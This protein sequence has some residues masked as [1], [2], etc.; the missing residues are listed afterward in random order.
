[1]KACIKKSLLV[2]ALGLALAGQAT[3]Q[4]LTVLYSFT[5]SPDGS[6]P[7][8][9]LTLSGSALYGT[10]QYGGEQNNPGGGTVFKINTDGSGE[11]VLKRFD[12]VNSFG[13]GLTPLAGLVTDG[14]MLYGT[15]FGGG[16]NPG[17][18]TVFKMNIN[19]TGYTVLHAFIRPWDGE[20]PTAGLTLSGNTLYGTANFGPSNK[21]GMVY[22]VK[23]DGTDYMG[24]H[25]F[26]TSDGAHPAADLVLSG[27]GVLYGT[28]S[29]G[30]TNGSVG[31]VFSLN[32]NG[33]EFKVLHHFASTDG[34][35]PLA[36]LVLDG[37]T[38]Y[39]TTSLGGA[40]SKGTIFKLNT[41]GSGFTNLHHFAGTGM[42]GDGENPTYGSVLTLSGST[43]YGA[44]GLGGGGILQGFGTLFKVKT[45]GTSYTVLHR[46]DGGSGGASPRG[47]LVLKDGALYGTTGGGGL[48]YGTVFKLDLPIP[49][50]FQ[51]TGNAIIL[52]WDDPTFAL[53]TA[54]VVTG[55]YTNILG[56]TS[57]YTNAITGP[58]QFF[59]LSYY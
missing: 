43:L 44:T 11:T 12:S 42:G 5:N 52:S 19:G 58:Q 24:L 7:F 3:A 31:T 29:A 59:R 34:A 41:D 14:S 17:L 57:P 51:S 48:G 35:N 15:T 49:L 13:D 8:S 21:V 33:S 38:L 47:G 37:S 20:S 22:S 18:G 10:T 32:T 54:H 6:G 36:S 56:A 50:F 4:T 16:V 9:G 27:E 40:H 53:Q 23:T 26:S 39:G 2:T 46:F 45:D 55:T 25:S 28:T 30:G 1:M